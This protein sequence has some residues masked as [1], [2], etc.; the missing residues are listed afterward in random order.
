MFLTINNE[1]VT[2]Y[3]E[4]IYLAVERPNLFCEVDTGTLV[5]QECFM[6]KMF[7]FKRLSKLKT[8][9]V[10]SEILDKTIIFL[11]VPEYQ[12]ISVLSKLNIV[13]G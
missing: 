4:I 1:T 12:E 9:A 13:S 8:Q 3:L 6:K 11:H 5:P 10:F 2:H 7:C